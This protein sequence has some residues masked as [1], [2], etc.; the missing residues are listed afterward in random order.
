MNMNYTTKSWDEQKALIEL[1]KS[2]GF[3][4]SSSNNYLKNY[5]FATIYVTGQHIGRDR[6]DDNRVTL[7]DFVKWLEEN[8]PAKIKNLGKVGDYALEATKNT[9]VVGCQNIPFS[10]VERVYLA[11]KELR[12]ES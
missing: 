1:A 12:G 4:V 6:S 11:M 5:D 3:E 9:I 10:E 8:K 2:F 7:I